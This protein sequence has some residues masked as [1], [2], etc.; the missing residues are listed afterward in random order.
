M[1]IHITK[2]LV[3]YIQKVLT[4]RGSSLYMDFVYADSLYTITSSINFAQSEELLIKSL[5]SEFWSNFFY[6]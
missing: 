2:S 1:N 3:T 5:L 4:Y 6:Y